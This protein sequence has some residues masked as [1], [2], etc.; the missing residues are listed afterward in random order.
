MTY[1]AIYYLISIAISIASQHLQT[2][3]MPLHVFVYIFNAFTV[4]YNTLWQQVK[5]FVQQINCFQLFI[6]HQ[7]YILNFSF[8]LQFF[9]YMCKDA[10]QVIKRSDNWGLD[11]GV[12]TS[13]YSTYIVFTC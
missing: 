1:I 6:D 8:C 10:S 13:C 3:A 5:H 12:S 11:N 4:A 7:K 2:L 9:S